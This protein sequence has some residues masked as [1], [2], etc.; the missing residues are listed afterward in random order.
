MNDDNRNQRDKLWKMIK[1]IKFAMFTTQHGNGHLHARPMTTQNKGLDED[2]SLWFFMSKAG[3]P[4][5]DLID[6][7]TVAVIYADPG[8]DTYVSVSGSAAV[9][10][11]AAKKKQLWNKA[12]DAWFPNGPTDPDA[13]LVQVQI[14]HANY[15][16]VTDSKPVQLFKMAAAAVTGKPP[17]DMGEHGEVRMR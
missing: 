2:E 7:P 14:V 4:V 3:D 16:D 12:N 9:I 10:E 13:A 8:S 1:D 17:T 11:D 5:A 6:N 15:W